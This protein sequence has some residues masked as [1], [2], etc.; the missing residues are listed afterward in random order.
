MWQEIQVFF[1]FLHMEE[2]DASLQ[3]TGQMLESKG[4]HSRDGGVREGGTTGMSLPGQ[5]VGKPQT[6]WG[7]PWTAI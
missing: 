3:P 7:R 6:L 2:G 4:S 5:M 1:F